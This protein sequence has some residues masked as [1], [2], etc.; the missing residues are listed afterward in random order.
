[1]SLTLRGALRNTRTAPR[2]RRL[3]VQGSRT[4]FM[5]LGPTAWYD[6]RDLL[7]TSQQTLVNRVSGSANSAQLGSTSGSDTNDPVALPAPTG[8]GYVYLPGTLGNNLSVVKGAWAGTL[9]VTATLV[10]DSTAT[11][12]TTADPVLIG[13]TDLAAGRYKRFDVR[14]T[15]GSGTLRVTINLASDTLGQASFTCTTGQTVTVNRTSSGLTTGIVTRPKLMADG[16]DD[17]VQLPAGDTPTFTRSAGSYT[18]LVVARIHNNQNFDRLFDAGSTAN[19][20]VNIQLFNTTSY[21]FVG[22]GTT[23]VS[24]QR[25]FSLTTLTVFGAVVNNGSIYSYT[26][27]N[28]LSAGSS[29]TGLT[30][31]PLHTNP[32]IGSVRQ[33]VTN[34]V[35]GEYFAV[36]I[37]NNRA[38]TA[39]ELN[40]ASTFLTGTYA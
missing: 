25:T 11:F 23:N 35:D 21:V 39:T 17:Y 33:F 10:D 38:L 29:I 14:D 18:A 8:N 31:D 15:N 40:T 4:Q 27:S 13:G 26:S 22:D 32:W 20:S 36:V 1:M 5:A 3:G 2:R 12:T 16:T 34:L 7:T 37:W 24:A 19:R 30:A 28:G 9:H 6:A